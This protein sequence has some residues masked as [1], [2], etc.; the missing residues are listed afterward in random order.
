MY[1]Y[2]WIEDFLDVVMSLDPDVKMVH[3][4][5]PRPLLPAPS[6][7]HPTPCTLHL[8]LYTLHPTPYTHRRDRGFMKPLGPGCA[9]EQRGNNLKGVKDFYLKDTAWTVLYVPNS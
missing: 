5:Q 3:K 4:G 6:I 2:D 9:C 8:T 1:I 7:L